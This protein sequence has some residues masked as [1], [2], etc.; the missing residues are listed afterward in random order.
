[1][2]IR[3]PF[4]VEWTSI[5]CTSVHWKYGT[6][7]GRANSVHY[8]PPLDTPTG[9]PTDVHL[10][11]IQQRHVCKFISWTISSFIYFE[12]FC[13]KN[14]KYFSLSLKMR[15]LKRY[16][17]MPREARKRTNQ[18]FDSFLI[19]TN[20]FLVSFTASFWEDARAEDFFIDMVLQMQVEDRVWCVPV[21]CQVRSW[22][23]NLP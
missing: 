19:W 1:M 16:Q 17:R 14:F 3:P 20:Q 4:D 5:W 23:A 15:L 12:V 7:G 2:G 6:S 8:G 9:R 21:L 11:P 13:P 22:K 10:R 18:I